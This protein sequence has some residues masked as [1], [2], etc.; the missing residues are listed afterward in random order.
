M[1]LVSFILLAMLPTGYCQLNTLAV[2]AGKKY[3]GTATDN[4]ELTD[5]P[6]V[7]QLGNTSD[8]NQ[9][10]AVS[11]SCGPMNFVT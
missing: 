9:I 6:Y 7:T 2:K 1:N 3:F 4:P 8:F 5:T 11:I 10:T